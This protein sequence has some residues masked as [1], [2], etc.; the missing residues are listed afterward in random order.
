MIVSRQMVV[1]PVERSPMMSSR[2][3][4]PIGII[5]SIGMMPVCTGWPIG[6][7]ADDAGSD[8]LDG[9]GDVARDRT[10][11]VERFA[12]R[13]DDAA[14]EPLADRHLQQL[15]G[16]LDLAAFFELGVVAENDDADLGLVE[17]QRHAGDAL[18]EVEHLVQHHVA[19][20]L[21]PCHAVADLA[22]DADGL[23][24]ACGLCPGDVC[25]DFLDQIG[26]GVPTSL[27]QTGVDRG[28]PGAHAAVVDI[29]ADADPHA[30]DERGIFGERRL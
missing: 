25:F 2:C 14:E 7:A 19:E 10:L 1:L 24:G 21:D 3:P 17:V 4:R 12:E 22:D 16:G 29:A 11:A 30:G 13:V 23:L 18:P 5:A 27:S 8:L 6:L 26:H 15:A 28:Q 20:P 9:I